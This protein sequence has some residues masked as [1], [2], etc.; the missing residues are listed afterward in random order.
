MLSF[1]EDIL[2]FMWMRSCGELMLLVVVLVT[3]EIT[4]FFSI[5]NSAHQTTQE[6]YNS[7]RS[8][9]HEERVSSS[10]SSQKNQRRTASSQVDCSPS[11]HHDF[12]LKTTAARRIKV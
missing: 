12:D 11:R 2:R 6:I 8:L 4:C 7:M 1:L 3:L 10:G 5:Y 9:L